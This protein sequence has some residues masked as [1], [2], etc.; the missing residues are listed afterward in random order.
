VP[1]SVEKPNGFRRTS[2]HTPPNPERWTFGDGSKRRRTL[3]RHD[4]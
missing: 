2:E 4:N 3:D 1:Y